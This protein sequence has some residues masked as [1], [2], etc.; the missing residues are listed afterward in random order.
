MQGH[1]GVLGV[2]TWD[3]KLGLNSLLKLSARDRGEIT[4]IDHELSI[5]SLGQSLVQRW[6]YLI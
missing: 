4:R 5:W 3:E 6:L 2:S 1:L